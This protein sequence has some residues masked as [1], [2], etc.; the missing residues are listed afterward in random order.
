MPPLA[1]LP[2]RAEVQWFIN[3]VPADEWIPTVGEHK[4]KVARGES[5]D[6]ITIYYE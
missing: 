4:V 5:T 6:E 3:D 2:A 1:A